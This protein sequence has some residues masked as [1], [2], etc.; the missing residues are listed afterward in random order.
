VAEHAVVHWLKGLDPT[1]NGLYRG[2]RTAIA[3][4]VML[5]F[6]LLVGNP[7]IALIGVFG[8]VAT[9]LFVELPGNRSARWSGYLL[10]GIFGSVLICL[11]TL[12]SNNTVTAVVGMAVVGLAILF[13][14]V[15]SAGA[16]AAGKAAILLFLLPVMVPALPP[17]IPARLLGWV[18]GWAVSVSLSMFLWPR[19]DFDRLRAAVSRSCRATARAISAPYGLD[20]PAQLAQVAQTS[21]DAM[22]DLRLAFRVS[23]SRPVGLSAGGRL[24]GR[25]INDL[26]SLFTDTRD[27]A[28]PTASSEVEPVAAASAAVL[29]AAADALD[30]R[31]TSNRTQLEASIA[32][33]GTVREQAL[34]SWLG[35][36]LG[37]GPA[38]AGGATERV[39][40]LAYS[41][42][43]V[44]RHIAASI[45]ADARPVLDKLLGRGTTMV[46]ADP[47][48]AIER[49]SRYHLNWRSVWFHNSLRGALGLA[50]AVLVAQLL[51]VQHGFW[52][53]LGTLSVLRSTATNTGST[54]LRAVLGTA[55]GVVVASPILILLGGGPGLWVALPVGLFLAG[56]AT[57]VLPLA[58]GQGAFSA[59]VLVLF[60]LLA[61]GTPPVG[62]VRVE[63]VA[64]GAVTALVV[65]VLLW[66][67]G[68][69]AEIRRA[70]AESYR[71]G[72]RLLEVAVARVAAPADGRAG[73]P[74]PVDLVEVRGSSL[75]LDDALRQYLSDRG[76]KTGR[77]DD[78][79][80][81]C[82]GAERLRLSGEAIAALATAL[83]DSTSPPAELGALIRRRTVELTHWQAG[84]AEALDGRNA[85]SSL[86]LSD[87]PPADLGE[88]LMGWVR[89]HS[90][91]ARAAL[92]APS[93]TPETNAPSALVWTI[94]HLDHVARIQVRVQSV[95]T[96]VLPPPAPVSPRRAQMSPV[97][98]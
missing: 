42:D 78:L 27:L 41:T 79:V 64:I 59:A 30:D 24:L 98:G 92:T 31:S 56:F 52:V 91:D 6:G 19:H 22:N 29:D 97:A 54:A 12:A 85:P 82:V 26:E 28:G 88:Q 15:L 3:G 53:G 16:A 90:G 44:G 57:A 67:R 73:D 76:A 81:V 48:S 33:L 18:L 51:D 9:L 65:G 45:D 95:V 93:R 14:G 40:G 71:A 60:A 62:L 17:E 25:T 23:T 37:G 87:P 36:V 4:T 55:G 96:R 7:Q 21:L 74:V 69:A 43:E 38:S 35:S 89:S 20:D 46:D 66:P 68:A 63:D 70:A 58:V 83:P 1:H 34:S 8:A 84:L 75:R 94:I 72:A 50:L 80:L 32:T 61:P 13:A 49:L 86:P 39:H 5:A 10:L 47:I 77:I 2:I 11:G